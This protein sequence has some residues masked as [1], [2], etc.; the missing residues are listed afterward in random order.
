MK[1][2]PTPL[3]DVQES[4]RADRNHAPLQRVVAA[5]FARQL[6]RDRHELIEA[7]GICIDALEPGTPLG[8]KQMQD[9]TARVQWL[10][11]TRPIRDEARALLE[12]MK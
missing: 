8:P 9:F 4:H 11:L 6:E 5:D 12:R 7:L 2:I 1:E 3:T 10:D